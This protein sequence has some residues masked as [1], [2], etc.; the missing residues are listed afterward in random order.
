MSEAMTVYRAKADC[1]A[2][3]FYRRAGETFELPVFK[4]GVCPAHLEPVKSVK[5]AMEPEGKDAAEQMGKSAKA[6]ANKTDK[7]GK[8]GKP[9]SVPPAAQVSKE[10]IGVG[11]AKPAQDVTSADMVKQ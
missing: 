3:G 9:V 11:A 4:D 2:G 7:A 8:V 5:S 10:D 6:A 1:R